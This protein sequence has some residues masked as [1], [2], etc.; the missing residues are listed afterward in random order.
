MSMKQAHKWGG[1]AAAVKR[2][3]E[4]V[5][6]AK[7]ATRPPIEVIHGIFTDKDAEM[8][9]LTLADLELLLARLQRTQE[10]LTACQNALQE[11][12]G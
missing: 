10:A 1:S 8:A 11:Q 9:D 4:Y 5:R 7:L 3:D 6:Q 12:E 2:I